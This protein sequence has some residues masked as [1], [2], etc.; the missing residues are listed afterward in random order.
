MTVQAI[1]N[2][3]TTTVV[4]EQLLRIAQQSALTSTLPENSYLM[5]SCDN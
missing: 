1:P 3:S 2:P 5:Q 4:T